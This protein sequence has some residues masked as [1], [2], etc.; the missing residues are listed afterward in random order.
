MLRTTILKKQLAKLR[1]MALAVAVICGLLV[2]L[3]ACQQDKIEQVTLSISS[4]E[5]LVLPSSGGEIT[6][7]I[8]TNQGQWRAISSASWLK[9]RSAGNN[10]IVEAEA[11]PLVEERIAQI[12]LIAASRE[13]Q[14]TA[15][16]MVDGKNAIVLSQN[17]LKAERLAKQ[18]RIL[19]KTS[20][21]SWRAEVQGDEGSWI[22]LLPRPRYGELIVSL[23]EN[24]TREQRSCRILLRDGDATSTLSV[25]QDGLPFFF[26]PYMNWGSDYTDAELFEQERGSRLTLRPRVANPVQGQRAIPYFQFSTVSSAF[27]HVHYEFLEFGPRFLYKATLIAQDLSVLKGDELSNFLTKEQ[28]VQRTDIQSNEFNKYYVNEAKK[29]N[30]QI[31]INSEAREARLIFTPIVEQPKGETYLMPERLPLGFPITSQSTRADV[32]AWEL[33]AKGE[34]NKTFSSSNSDRVFYFASAPYYYRQY[35]YEILPAV[36][37][38][39]PNGADPLRRT[40]VTLDNKYQG[41]YRYGGLFFVTKELEDLLR[42]EG[43]TFEAYDYTIG[44]Y[45]YVNQTKKLRLQVGIS[46]LVPRTELTLIQVIPIKD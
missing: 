5:E 25:E 15:R 21:D 19:V 23:E 2:S 44:A 9:L 26:L 43:F 11:N 20:S 12:I 40:F 31:F 24:R 39:T 7:P 6:L 35:L 42:E 3:Q 37:G 16:Q 10:L 18:Y 17:D 14:L 27:Q 41:V 36:G 4:K 46:T 32:E 33:M 28:Y 34:E 22:T 1:A 38:A 30:L 29:I 8:T 45:F 13:L